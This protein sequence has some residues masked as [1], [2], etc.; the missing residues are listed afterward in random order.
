MNKLQNTHL[1]VYIPHLCKT[2]SH[3]YRGFS[4]YLKEVS[5][6]AI[7]NAVATKIKDSKQLWIAAI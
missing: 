1:S 5:W 4:S 7:L 6:R 3:K 2:K